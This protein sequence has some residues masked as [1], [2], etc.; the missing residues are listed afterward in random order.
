MQS[1]TATVGYSESAA[2][3]V[4]MFVRLPQTIDVTN[5]RTVADSLAAALAVNPSLVVA[6]ATATIFCDCAGI[7]ALVCAHR[8]AADAGAE[9]RIVAASA[10]VRR[11][12][13]L[14]AADHVL[15]VYLT[16]DDALADMTGPGSA[17]ASAVPALTDETEGPVAV[18]G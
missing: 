14:T 1:M 16:M 18:G 5:D 11:V 7:S 10:R 17:A 12:M 8:Q 13:K 3:Y 4:I 9:L 6:D 2:D 15:D